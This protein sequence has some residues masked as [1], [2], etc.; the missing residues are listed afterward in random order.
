MREAAADEV[1]S[2][3]DAGSLLRGLEKENFIMESDLSAALKELDSLY[4]SG[5]KEETEKFI[6]K[7]LREYAPCCGGFRTEHITFLNEAGEYY[8]RCGLYKKSEYYYKYAAGMVEAHL[9]HDSESYTI[10]LSNLAG[11]Y[12]LMGN[13]E[14]A[15]KLLENVLD[16]YSKT[17]GK[18]TYLYANTLNNIALIHMETGN[19][20][21]AASC[22]EKALKILRRLKDYRKE[23]GV[24]LGNL[25]NAYQKL[26]MHEKAYDLICESVAILR[27]EA[28]EHSYEYAFG[29]NNLAYSNIYK[30]EYTAAKECYLQS[31]EI[32]RKNMGEENTDY[33]ATLQGLSY[34]CHALNDI[35]QAR[36]CQ[37][38]ACEILVKLFGAE[39]KN[40]I[41]AQKKLE[42]LLREE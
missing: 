27:E 4:A 25:A 32:I 3:T 37:K 40:T 29:L 2:M 31:A 8:M 11:I 38:R 34:V 30:K 35:E 7:K 22:Q 19:Y 17:I 28:S 41:E 14:E 24:S 18:E 13:F 10:I 1:D 26:N 39:N 36:A 33:A 23:Y 20:Q 15:S 9:G 21:E 16:L 12:R 5:N 42:A 6:Q